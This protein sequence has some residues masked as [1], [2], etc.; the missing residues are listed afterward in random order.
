MSQ[1][2]PSR[3]AGGLVEA[4]GEHGGDVVPSIL[5]RRRRIGTDAAD[6]GLGYPGLE[7]Q[8]A[9]RRYLSET[10]MAQLRRNERTA[11][12]EADEALAPTALTG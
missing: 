8:V 9:E 11:V 10:S 2:C 4:L 12:A 6:L 5:E 1:P 3:V 7:W